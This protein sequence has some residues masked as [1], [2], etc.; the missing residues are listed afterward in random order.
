MDPAELKPGDWFT[1]RDIQP[2]RYRVVE[3]L[4]DGKL[5]V[6]SEEGLTGQIHTINREFK[7]AV[8]PAAFRQ[9][10][11]EELG[12]TVI[13]RVIDSIGTVR[14]RLVTLES[15][16][17]GGTVRWVEATSGEW[18]DPEYIIDWVP[19]DGL[20][21]IRTLHQSD[22][23]PS[24]FCTECGHAWPCRAAVALGVVR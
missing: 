8:P 15:I 2:L 6:E 11:P 12:T 13:V 10:L 21:V 9:P 24:P 5:L 3:P 16:P 7:R 4:D 19:L 18:V 17:V 20:D 22:G 1:W 14:S 23:N